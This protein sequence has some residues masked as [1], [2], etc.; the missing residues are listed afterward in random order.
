MWYINNGILFRH[1]KG[2]NTTIRKNTNEKTQ[3]KK[4]T[5]RKRQKLHVILYTQDLFL[6]SQKSQK[7]RVES[8]CQGGCLKGTNSQL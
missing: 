7:Q 1:E 5:Y 4:T 2:A 3:S 6:K 8:G